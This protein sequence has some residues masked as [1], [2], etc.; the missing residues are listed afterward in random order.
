MKET[1][2]IT[3]SSRGIGRVAA[4]LFAADGYNIAINYLKSRIAAEALCD[5]LISQGCD[6][7]AIQADVSDR[8][9]VDEM[10]KEISGHFGYISALVNNAGIAQEA[11]FSDITIADWDR[12]LAVNLTGVFNCCQ[13]VL[14]LMLRNH[15][16]SIVNVSS[17]WGVTGGSCEVH[18]SAAKAGVIGLTKALAK[19]LGPSGIRVNCVAPGVIDTDMNAGFSKEDFAPLLA[20][21][22]AGRRGKAEEVANAILFLASRKSSYITGQVLSVDGGFVI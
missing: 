22:A 10:V 13:A 20:Q 19:E 1:V 8:L 17:M 5:K 4:E 6:A 11:V 12:M 3:G 16:G 21:T 7:I 2:L 9:Q 18:Y 14:P 15:S